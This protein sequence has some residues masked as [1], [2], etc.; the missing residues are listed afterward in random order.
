[1]VLLLVAIAVG[2]IIV[3]ALIA[4][5]YRTNPTDV[6]GVDMKCKRCGMEI[7]G[8]K[9]PRCEKEKQSFGV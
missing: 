2:V 6:L 1:M 9:C 3:V 5:Y 7:Q 8:L 4:K